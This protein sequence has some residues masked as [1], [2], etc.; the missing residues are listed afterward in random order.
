ML[1]SILQ[2]TDSLRDKRTAFHIIWDVS[3]N[4]PIVNGIWF[5]FHS[6]QLFSSLTNAKT[7]YMDCIQLLLMEGSMWF[8]LILTSFPQ[9]TP[10]LPKVFC[11]FGRILWEVP[12]GPA[13]VRQI[14]QKQSPSILESLLQFSN[15]LSFLLVTEPLSP[16]HLHESLEVH[17]IC[18]PIYLRIQNKR[19]AIS[20]NAEVQ[21]VVYSYFSQT[22]EWDRISLPWASDVLPWGFD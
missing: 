14:L 8:L 20:V 13:G 18:K 5:C 15:F 17:L 2:N 6:A 19:L 11:R 4:P 9:K 7:C 12:Q 21:N 3:W 10:A 16:R 22:R 1:E